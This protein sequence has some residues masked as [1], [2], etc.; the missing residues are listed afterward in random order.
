MTAGD[1]LLKS[2]IQSLPFIHR[3]KVRDL[4]AVDDDKL[5]VVQTDRLSVF[6]HVRQDHHL[7]NARLLV[8]IRHIDLQFA[9]TRAEV[10]L[11]LGRQLLARETDRTV[12]TQCHH[13]G[14]N[15][16]VIESL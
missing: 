10:K 13:D 1:A 6:F 5:L 8:G 4:Y 15:H 2:D 11:L 9:K 16:F 12:S 14:L 3:G 7:R